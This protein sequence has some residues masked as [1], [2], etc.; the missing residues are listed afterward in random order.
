MA[1]ALELYLRANPDVAAMAPTFLPITYTITY[2]PLAVSVVNS[3]ANVTT[4][5]GFLCLRISATQTAVGNATYITTPLL[6]TLN[7]TAKNYNYTAQQTE[8]GTAGIQINPQSATN[9][10]DLPWPLKIPNAAVIQSFVTN[11]LAVQS[12]VW[13]SFIGIQFQMSPA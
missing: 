7:I 6:M 8:W 10:S 9:D 2:S 12:N 1:S 3:P 4:N 13:I 11:P 5:G